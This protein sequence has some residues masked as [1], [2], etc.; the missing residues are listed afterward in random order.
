MANASIYTVG[1]LVQANDRGQYLVRQADKDLLELCQQSTFAYILTS[2]QMGKSSLMIHT[3]EELIT[4]GIKVV[5]IDLSGIGTELS[6]D[7]WYWGILEV[8]RDQLQLSANMEAWWDEYG[9]LGGTQRLTHFFEQVLLPE[10]AEPVV[11]FVDEID[12][13]LSLDFTDDFF[14]AIRS[15]YVARE[16]QPEFRRLTFVLSGVAT[17]S[18][19][20]QDLKRT[21]FNIGRAI[22]LEGFHLHEVTPLTQSL[23]EKVQDPNQ[24]VGEILSWTGG[25]PFLTQKLCYLVSEAAGANSFLSV[26]DIVRF[27]I[28]ENWELHDQPQHLGTIRNRLLS[29]KELKNRLFSLYQQI[30]K[31]GEVDC[32]DSD[33]QRQLLLSGLAVKQQGKLIIANRIYEQIFNDTWVVKELAN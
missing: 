16:K 28:A 14:A 31:A 22:N 2:R 32:E 30:L 25:Q 4:Q 9:Y 15:L 5:I 19:L 12:T 3:A 29:N 6:A 26:E 8:I 7:Q 17:P 24:V 18:D 20:M 10:I 13:T 1:G 21:P 23:I 27:Q 33:V 11:I